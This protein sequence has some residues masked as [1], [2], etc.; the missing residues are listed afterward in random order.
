MQNKSVKC[1]SEIL[2][3]ECGKGNLCGCLSALSA[4]LLLRKNV[5][6]GPFMQ[7]CNTQNLIQTWC[8][9]GKTLSQCPCVWGA[10]F[11]L[12]QL[13]LTYWFCPWLHIE[14][15]VIEN[16]IFLIVVPCTCPSSRMKY[17]TKSPLLGWILKLTSRNWC[18]VRELGE[19]WRTQAMILCLCNC[20]CIQAFTCR[21]SFCHSLF[22][23][24]IRGK[25]LPMYLPC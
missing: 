17:N 24:S 9:T 10:Y 21:H 13:A 25:N 23:P 11:C 7:F 4:H 15:M 1:N 3:K 20:V 18:K 22:F 12:L 2:W 19:L 16:C 5:T 14:M 6:G 8:G